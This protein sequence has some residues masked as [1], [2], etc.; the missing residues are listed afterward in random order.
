MKSAQFTVEFPSSNL[1]PAHVDVSAIGTA[2]EGIT[3]GLPT[4]VTH[5]AD[6]VVPT[7]GSSGDA[8]VVGRVSADDVVRL[9]AKGIGTGA[10]TVLVTVFD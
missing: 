3:A 10:V 5:T 2:L 6:H 1:Q 8:V 9:S 7:I 4:L